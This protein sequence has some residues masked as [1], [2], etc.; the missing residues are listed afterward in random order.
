MPQVGRSRFISYISAWN[1]AMGAF[2]FFCVAFSCLNAARETIWKIKR[3]SAAS[4]PPPLQVT[5]LLSRAQRAGGNYGGNESTSSLFVD[6][7][8]LISPAAFPAVTWIWSLWWLVAVLPTN[9]IKLSS[10][11]NK[12]PNSQSVEEMCPALMISVVWRRSRH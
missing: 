11:R 6:P 12:S 2:F 7:T 8:C 3:P 9:G 1:P 4:L 5:G 10:N